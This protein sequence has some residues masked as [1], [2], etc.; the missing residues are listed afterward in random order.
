VPFTAEEET[1]FPVLM[2]AIF[3][4]FMAA[5]TLLISWYI[6][7]EA[8]EIGDRIILNSTIHRFM[9]RLLS[10]YSDLI[11]RTHEETVNSGAYYSPEGEFKTQQDVKYI[12][13]FKTINWLHQTFG[14]DDKSEE[15]MSDFFKQLMPGNEGKKYADL[16]GFKT[17]YDKF[18]KNIITALLLAKGN[19]TEV[20]HNDEAMSKLFQC[21]DGLY[22]M[23]KSL[24]WKDS[25]IET[26]LGKYKPVDIMENIGDFELT[27]FRIRHGINVKHTR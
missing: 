13:S 19:I 8:E 16:I 4:L 14:G 24:G 15:K 21:A 27:K 9:D 10:E 2:A 25:S 20:I 12:F 22:Q 18:E 6:K 26:S 3:T 7:K 23:M 1:D 11:I 5:F 17:N